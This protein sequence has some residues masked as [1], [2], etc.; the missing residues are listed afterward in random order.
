MAQAI[1]VQLMFT[2]QAQEAIQHYVTLF[3][4]SSI[5]QVDLYGP[6]QMG[7][8]GTVKR[9]LFTIA[10]RQF[11]AI[12]SPPVHAFTFT[13]STSFFVDCE[14]EEEFDSACASLSEGGAHLMPP[15]NYGFSQKFVW[16]NDRF[17]VSWQLNLP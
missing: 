1:T 16:L 17:G 11:A 14:T 8:E 5:D 12:D 15:S 10:G 7:A 13:P 6:G 9:A 4:N 3:A 2:G